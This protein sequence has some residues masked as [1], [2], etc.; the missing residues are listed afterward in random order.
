MFELGQNAKYSPRAYVFR[1]G[2]DNGHDAATTAGPF[3][4]NRLHCVHVRMKDAV[5]AIC[6]KPK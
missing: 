1:F 4:A 6:Q 5:E 2:P 3:S